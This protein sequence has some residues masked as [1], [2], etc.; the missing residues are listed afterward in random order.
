M[1]GYNNDYV[2]DKTNYQPGTIQ[3]THE[4]VLNIYNYEYKQIA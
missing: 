2:Y 1:L 3:L 4:Q